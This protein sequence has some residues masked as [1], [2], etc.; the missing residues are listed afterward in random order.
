MH[1]SSPGPPLR[2]DKMLIPSVMIHLTPGCGNTTQ[3]R[4]TKLS[5]WRNINCVWHYL[6]RVSSDMTV[7]VL[8]YLAHGLCHLITLRYSLMSNVILNTGSMIF[9]MAGQSRVRVG[10][11]KQALG[12][13]HCFIVINH[14]GCNIWILGHWVERI[15]SCHHF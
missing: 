13:G 8:L 10:G 3:D 11:L 6:P 5:T 15:F 7:I 14:P 1:G 2:C 9:Q 12:L 4:N